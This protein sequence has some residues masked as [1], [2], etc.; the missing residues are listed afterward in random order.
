MSVVTGWLDILAE[1]VDDEGIDSLERVQQASQ[2]VI[3]LTEVARE[4]VEIVANEETLD[5]HPVSLDSAIQEEIAARREQYPD[6]EFTVTG[7]VPE[8]D[9]Q[10]NKMLPSVFRNLLNNAI[11]HN[12]SET[13]RIDIEVERT[14]EY[15]TV[16]VAD[17][18]PGI[19][20]VQKETVFGKGEQGL[21]SP[22]TGIGLY[23]VQN[24]VDEFGGEVWIED[25][26]PTGAVVNVTFQR[27]E[28]Q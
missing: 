5:L 18:G 19:P 1:H 27:A 26:V 23:L 16:S 9:V 10:A 24:L 28:T 17:N 6:A 22:G 13:P 14:D 15:V 7:D 2:R 11:Q 25:N 12:D 3:D 8:V 21:E 4:Y 20:D